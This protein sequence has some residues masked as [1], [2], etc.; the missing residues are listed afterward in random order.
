M[1]PILPPVIISDAI[2]SVYKVIA[3]WMPVTVVPVSAATCRIETFITELSSV[4]KNWPEASTDSTKPLPATRPG[5]P[6]P[7]AVGVAL[8]T[9]RD[10]GPRH[11]SDSYLP[12]P[13][14]ISRA[15]LAVSDP[16]SMQVNEGPV[17]DG[18]H[19]QPQSGRYR[20]DGKQLAAVQISGC[21]ARG[22]RLGTVAWFMYARRRP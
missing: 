15:R 21:D 8:V 10:Y 18:D 11:P 7:L 1:A 6:V 22:N 2:T 19:Q 5:E 20:R 9:C 17:L 16:A 14:G 4:I 12:S 3:V 13:A